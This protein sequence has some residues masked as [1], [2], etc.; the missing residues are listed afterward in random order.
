M[1]EDEL[2]ERRADPVDLKEVMQA[3]GVSAW[4][5]LGQVESSAAGPLS[6]LVEIEGKPYVLKALAD[7]LA[8]G[9]SEAMLNQ[10]NRTVSL[11]VMYSRQ[12][13]GR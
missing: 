2:E 6:L 12:C 7:G 4:Q 9:S 1:H 5:N 3:F 10:H 11:A 8:G 13:K